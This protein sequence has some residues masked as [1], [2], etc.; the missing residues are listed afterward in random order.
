M[1]ADDYPTP[2]PTRAVSWMLRWAKLIAFIAGLLVG[3]TSATSAAMIWGDTRFA[4]RGEFL[5]H[6]K[7]ESAFET[8][9]DAR[10]DQE[11]Y[12]T[13][14]E[15]MAGHPATVQLNASQEVRLR[16]LERNQ[17]W[18]A[19]ALYAMARRQGIQLNAPPL[20]IDPLP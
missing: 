10:F 15:F 2:P 4:G 8:K 13:R 5:N 6:V 11:K 3:F 16:I 12:V 1:T 9:V 20:E 17:R 19:G 7:A 18:V 14:D